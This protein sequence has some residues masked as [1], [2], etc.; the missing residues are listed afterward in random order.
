MHM[1]LFRGLGRGRL[2]LGAW[3]RWGPHDHV[4]AFS[5]GNPCCNIYRVPISFQFFYFT[6]IFSLFSPNQ[7][8]S[9]F[10]LVWY[11]R[12][13]WL[14]SGVIEALDSSPCGSPPP[15]QLVLSSPSILLS[16]F[17]D[18]IEPYTHGEFQRR[19]ALFFCS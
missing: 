3:W 10:G 8:S 5:F 11:I 17:L 15:T 13:S 12:G 7:R 1:A 18:I 4:R 2:S 6:F 19:W 9:W 16:T 14:S